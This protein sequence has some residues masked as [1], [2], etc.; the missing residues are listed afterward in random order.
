MQTI[1]IRLHKLG[2]NQEITKK[3]NERSFF[4]ENQGN[5]GTPGKVQ[6]REF[7]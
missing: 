7:F 5:L 2:Q 3:S 1:K 6:K 4:R